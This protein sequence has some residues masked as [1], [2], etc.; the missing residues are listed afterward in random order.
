MTPR[1]GS[2]GV[3]IFALMLMT[4]SLTV[5][6]MVRAGANMTATIAIST[7]APMTALV[8]SLVASV[9]L[10]R[11]SNTPP[12]RLVSELLTPRMGLFGVLIFVLMLVASS[13]TVVHMVSAGAKV[14]IKRLPVSVLVA[15]LVTALD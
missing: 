1:M 8:L 6:H 11:R 15:A 2:F 7:L 5:V 4:S 3:L 14:G 10:T 13:L 9:V 12:Q